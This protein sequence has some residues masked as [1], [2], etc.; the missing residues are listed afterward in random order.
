MKATATDILK[1]TSRARWVHAVVLTRVIVGALLL[2]GCVSKTSLEQADSAIDVEREGRR[3]TALQLAAAEGEVERLKAERE[4]LLEKLQNEEEETSSSLLDV[5]M[6]QKDRDHQAELVTQLRGELARVGE[7]LKS[8][9]GDSLALTEQKQQLEAQ[10]V[11][12]RAELALQGNAEGE[13]ADSSSAPP[14]PH[15]GTAGAQPPKSEAEDALDEPTTE[16]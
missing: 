12:L 16:K 11:N 7:H 1:R 3:R 5:T 10:V 13:D 14:V 2:G 6:T 15:L 4:A 8:F 9:A